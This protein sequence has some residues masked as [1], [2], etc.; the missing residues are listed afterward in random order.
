VT[1][2]RETFVKLLDEHG[3]RV[4]AFLRR[5]CGDVHD[6]EDLYQ[7]VAAR[8]WNNLRARPWLRNPRGWIMTIAYRTFLNHQARR[9][10]AHAP[11]L[12]DDAPAWRAREPDPVA[13]AELAERRLGLDEAVAG[14]SDPLR[15]VVLLHY[16]GG[17]SLREVA[18]TLEISVGTAKSRLNAGLEH[19]RGRMS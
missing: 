6:A 11:L 19:L 2:D 7:E 1:T 4:L 12:E 14:L 17:L 9:P 5:L 8:V 13:V 16:T 15:A 10:P 3:A 18:Q